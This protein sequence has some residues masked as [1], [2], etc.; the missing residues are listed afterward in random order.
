MVMERSTTTIGTCSFSTTGG[1]IRLTIGNLATSDA[2]ASDVPTPNSPLVSS[3]ILIN[4]TAAA[5]NITT[6]ASISAATSATVSFAI[7][8]PA[9]SI[10]DIVTNV[11]DIIGDDFAAAIA[12]FDKFGGSSVVVVATADVDIDVDVFVDSFAIFVAT[13]AVTSAA[14]AAVVESESVYVFE[15]SETFL[16]ICLGWRI[17][18]KAT[19]KADT[20]R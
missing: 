17:S 3:I 7:A 13:G 6:I 4:A 9:L 8:S 10:A 14:T 1:T 11:D 5:A 2:A 12:V 16:E 15:A 18:S 19:P 20:T